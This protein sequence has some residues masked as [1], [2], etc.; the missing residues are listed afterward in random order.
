MG[1]GRV[2]VRTATPNDREL[3]SILIASSYGELARGPYDPGTLA[4]ALPTMSR[5]NPKLL[6]IS[7]YYVAEISGTAAGCGGWTMAKPGSDEIVD[8]VGHIRHFATH[9]AHVR[10]GVGRLLLDVCLAE[11]RDA[12][13]L[14]L[15]SS[16]SRS[17][18]L[19]RSI[20]AAD[21]SMTFLVASIVA[22]TSGLAVSGAICPSRGGFSSSWAILNSCVGRG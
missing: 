13:M 1:D 4:A 3:L 12:G 7:T 8:G 21:C 2:V 17:R 18:R 22:R 10:K 19:A 6:A 16:V 9:P 11:A 5:A 20:S 14:E 15:S